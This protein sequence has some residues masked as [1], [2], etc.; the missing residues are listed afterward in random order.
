MKTIQSKG[1]QAMV[2]V[3]LLGLLTAPMAP[4]AEAATNHQGAH[5]GYQQDHFVVL[6]AH[7]A[8]DVTESQ[9]VYVAERACR[10]KKVDFYSSAA[11]T[12]AD[13]NTT[14]INLLD[15]ATEIA[16]YDL[17]NGNNLAA[18]VVHALYAP[19]TPRTLSAGDK[20]ILQFE[21]VGNGLLVPD[22]TVLVVIDF[23]P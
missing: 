8:A 4:M 16:N 15:Q 5:P 14:H 7:L 22:S 6:P 17:T 11:V 12:G 1:R 20:V 10:L 9:V 18:N 2:A 3:A 21:K 13:T 19:A 23:E